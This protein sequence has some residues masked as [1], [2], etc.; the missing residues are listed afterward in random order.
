MFLEALIELLF[1]CDSKEY[2]E[3]VLGTS[4]KKYLKYSYIPHKSGPKPRFPESASSNLID[5]SQ[6][7]PFIF[8]EDPRRP[9]TSIP[10]KTTPIS[11]HQHI[12]IITG[13]HCLIY[14]NSEEIQNTQIAKTESIVMG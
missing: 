8:K 9:R 6:K 14:R 11:Q 10:A 1:L 4:F 12:K 3:T 2:A 5:L 13:G 7:T